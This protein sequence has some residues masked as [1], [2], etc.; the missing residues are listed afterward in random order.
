M[1]TLKTDWVD[2]DY[3]N[4]KTTG[5]NDGFN[6]IANTINEIPKMWVKEYD[7]ATE[8]STTTSGAWQDGPSFSLIVPTGSYITNIYIETTMKLTTSNI[9]RANLKLTGTNLGTLYI[10]GAISYSQQVTDDS[11]YSDSL[12]QSTSY[13]TL[14]SIPSPLSESTVLLSGGRDSN[15]IKVR[16][17]PCI[18]IKLLDDST[19]ITLIYGHGNAGHTGSVKDSKILVSGFTPVVDEL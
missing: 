18:P 5:D 17:N 3:V 1:V 4:A 7:D 13:Q 11:K 6:G 19:T 12:N 14:T 16:A 9:V 2:G 10:T 15:D 8:F